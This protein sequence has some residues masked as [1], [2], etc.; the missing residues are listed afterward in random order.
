MLD[1]MFALTKPGGLIA[2]MT[3]PF[4]HRE[5]L[6]SFDYG[7]SAMPFKEK[8]HRGRVLDVLLHTYQHRYTFPRYLRQHFP[9]GTNDGRFLIHLEPV[10]LN[11]AA[12]FPDADAVYVADTTEIGEYLVR[13]GSTLV[14]HWPDLGYVL[15]RKG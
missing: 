1:R 15:V 9:R 5:Y 8:V 10:C 12:W 2:I 7:L 13:L 4:R 3:P 6:K 14:E 11:G